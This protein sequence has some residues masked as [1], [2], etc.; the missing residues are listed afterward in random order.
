MKYFLSVLML[1]IVIS[2]GD[3][4]GSAPVVTPPID[5]YVADT[6]WQ[7]QIGDIF[8]YRAQDGQEAQ[9]EI[10]ADGEFEWCLDFWDTTKLASYYTYICK[11]TEYEGTFPKVTMFG[12]AVQDTNILWGKR[13][14]D[15]INKWD[16]LPYYVSLF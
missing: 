11:F 8:K 9:L 2:C 10:L 12:A 7:P 16:R 3:D 14:V 5:T 13:D 6:I 4:K 1:M 15:I